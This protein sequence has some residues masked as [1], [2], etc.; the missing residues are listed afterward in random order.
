MGKVRHWI[1]PRGAFFFFFSFPGGG[2]FEGDRDCFFNWVSHGGL[3]APS[4]GRPHFC[5]CSSLGRTRIPPRVLRPPVSL[6]GDTD[7]CW[8]PGTEQ[9]KIPGLAEGRG[10]SWPGAFGVGE[11]GLPLRLLKP[12]S[13]SWPSRCGKAVSP[14][15]PAVLLTLQQGESLS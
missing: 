8:C 12:Q 13:V 4:A 3:Q 15:S 2:L 10:T 5:S 14:P 6:P 7:N 9:E 1:R 11:H